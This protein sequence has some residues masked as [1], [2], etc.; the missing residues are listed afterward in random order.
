MRLSIEH[1]TSYHYQAPATYSAQILRLTPA[2]FSGQEIVDWKIQCSPAV[3][4]R[5]GRDGFGNITHF[6]TVNRPHQHVEIVAAGVVATAD[7]AGIVAGLADPVPLAV[8]LRYTPLTE[9]APGIAALADSLPAGETIPWLHALMDAIREK[10][11]YVAGVTDPATTAAQA[12][13][14][15]HGVCQDHAHIFITAARLAGIPCR[16]VTGYLLVEGE[17]AVAQHAWAE[18]MVPG[19]GWLG[20]DPANGI[21]PT[22]HYVRLAAALDARYA[23]PI[24]GTHLGG[25]GGTLAVEVKVEQA[26]HQQ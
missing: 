9:P 3:V 13:S 16:Y 18:A 5:Q 17:Q 4:L 15:G 8:Y 20:F 19:L 11:A 12:L 24:R 25:G 1:R 7:T 14:A 22:D 23:A 26:S 21:C 10:V 6:L 2:A